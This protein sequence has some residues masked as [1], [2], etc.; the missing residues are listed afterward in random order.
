ML[1]VLTLAASSTLCSQSK[2]FLFDGKIIGSS[3]KYVG[4]PEYDFDR[5]YA[6]SVTIRQTRRDQAMLLHEKDKQIDI[7]AEQKENLTSELGRA[8]A[9]AIQALEERDD[10]LLDNADK[11][12]RI[13]RKNRK[14]AVLVLPAVYGV[15]KGVQTI[16]PIPWLP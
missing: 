10:V 11:K 16:V 13:K 15:L 2:V 4:L 3:G 8:K 1:L 9:A 12:K 5:A 7:L 14:I 6:R